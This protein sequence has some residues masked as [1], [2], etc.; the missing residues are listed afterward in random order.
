MGGPSGGNSGSADAPNTTRSKVSVKS[1]AKIAAKNVV[2]FVKGGGVIGAVA[3]T[4]NKNYQSKNKTSKSG[5]VYG[6]E[7][8]GYN[9]AAEKR[10]YNPRSTLSN[11]G[12]DRDGPSQK[13]IEQPKVAAQMDNTEVKSDLI[14]AKGPTSVEMSEDDILLQNKRKGRKRTVLTSVTGVQGYPTLSKKT[15]L[16]G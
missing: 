7:A 11:R 1:K 14:T 2:D 3:R 9:Q 6:G 13:S 5:D 16:G 15:L 4:I 10:D 8:Y 12:N